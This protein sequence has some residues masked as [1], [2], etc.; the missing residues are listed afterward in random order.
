MINS[1]LIKRSNQNFLQY[2]SKNI[3]N[4]QLFKWQKKYRN[5]SVNDIWLISIFNSIACW[6][7]TNWHWIHIS[8]DF[9]VIFC[10][11]ASKK[12]IS[13][14][15]RFFY[16]AILDIMWRNY[17]PAKG[18]YS[19]NEANLRQKGYNNSFNKLKWYV[20][21]SNAIYQMRCHTIND[22]TVHCWLFTVYSRMTIKLHILLYVHSLV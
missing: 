9:H 21:S 17:E 11:H 14:I 18:S 3:R 22:H 8:I 15:P 1:R 7:N 19:Q 13:S 20:I 4:E 10:K 2:L 16:S 5:S 6:I 12:F